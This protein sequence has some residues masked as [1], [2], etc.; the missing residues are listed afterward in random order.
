MVYWVDFMDTILSY[1][2]IWGKLFN[3]CETH[4]SSSVNEDN[5]YLPIIAM[6]IRHNK[7]FKFSRVLVTQ[8][9]FVDPT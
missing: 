4:V 6:S 3:F 7:F 5:A 9:I 8:F 1:Y 2:L